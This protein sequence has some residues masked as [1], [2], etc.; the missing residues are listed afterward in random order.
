MKRGDV[1]RAGLPRP[2]AAPGSEQFGTRPAVIIQ[3]DT[4]QS[5]LATTVIV[6][7][8]SNLQSLRFGGSIPV[9]PSPENGLTVRSVALCHQLRVID[10]RRIE[11]VLGHLAD[12]DMRAIESCIREF[13]QL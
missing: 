7:M 10:K 8:T 3:N 1:V 5:I 6:P 2:A 12:E 11:T 13:L 4:A 9:D